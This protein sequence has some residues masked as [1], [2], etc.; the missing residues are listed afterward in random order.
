MKHRGALGGGVDEIGL[1]S[2]MDGSLGGVKYRA[3]YDANKIAIQLL[4]RMRNLSKIQPHD[5]STVAINA[6]NRV[7]G[8]KR[9]FLGSLQQTCN[10][11][12]YL[13][14]NKSNLVFLLQKSSGDF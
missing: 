7:S 12:L 9:L 8:G 11:Y 14:I 10:E 3:P 2:G 1:W 5:F 6:V 13:N 4:C